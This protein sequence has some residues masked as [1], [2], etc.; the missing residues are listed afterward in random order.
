MSTVLTV[1]IDSRRE[2]DGYLLYIPSHTPKPGLEC[3][4]K[5]RK[6]ASRCPAY[7]ESYRPKQMVLIGYRSSSGC[8]AGFLCGRFF[9]LTLHISVFSSQMRHDAQH[10]FYEHQLT[11]AMHLVLL[12]AHQGLEPGLRWLA[13]ILGDLFSQLVIRQSFEE[14]GEAFTLVLQQI[15]ELLLRTLLFLLRL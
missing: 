13:R 15:D 11:A 9:H 14:S 3:G 12:V 1:P 2:R 4:L 7:G 8:L 10:A 5:F 6:R